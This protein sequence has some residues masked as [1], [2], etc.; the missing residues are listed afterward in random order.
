MAIKTSLALYRRTITNR[1][2]LGKTPVAP[3]ELG[4]DTLGR[5]LRI[6]HL[7]F[8]MQSS[9]SRM[10]PADI[11]LLD[12]TTALRECIDPMFHAILACPS[13]GKLD[14]VTKRQ[15]FGTEPVLCAH[16]DCACHFRIEQGRC[17]TYLRCN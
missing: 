11:L 14:F 3:P 8:V 4:C 15:Y 6:P 2:A 16:N 9:M 7:H 12:G 17:L 1:G 13:C 10:A 5:E